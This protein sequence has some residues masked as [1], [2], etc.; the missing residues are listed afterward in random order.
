MT[1]RCRSCDGMGDEAV[2]KSRAVPGLRNGGLYGKI[3]VG[4]HVST[5]QELVTYRG[6]GGPDEGQHFYCT[7]SQWREQFEEVT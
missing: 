5:L 3:C 2:A 1:Y 4:R 6:L 7:L